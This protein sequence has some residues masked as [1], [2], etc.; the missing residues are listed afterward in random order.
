M[1]GCGYTCTTSRGAQA[2]AHGQETK[3]ACDEE[4]LLMQLHDVWQSA[5]HKRTH[6]GESPMSARGKTAISPLRRA[7]TSPCTC[8]STPERN[9]SFV[10]RKAVVTGARSLATSQ[11]TSIPHCHLRSRVSGISTTAPRKRLIRKCGSET[12]VRYCFRNSS[13]HFKKT[14]LKSYCFQW[15]CAFLQCE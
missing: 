1:E 6:I 7:G 15:R 14:C 2:H 5:R 13:P 11:V 12:G 10:M 8:A 3:N 9:R 4:G